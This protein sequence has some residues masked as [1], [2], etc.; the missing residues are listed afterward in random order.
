MKRTQFIIAISCAA[1]LTLATSCSTG[2]GKGTVWDDQKTAGNYNPSR[3]L[4]GHD[5]VE[6]EES[7]APS[8]EDFV[9][10]NNDDLKAQFSDGAAPQ[11]KHSPGEVGSRLPGIEGFHNP[12][13]AETSVFKTLYFNTDDHI[14]RDKES[15]E[16]LQRVAA[17][18]NAHP[19]VFIFV[20]GNCDE[21]GPEGYNLALGTRRANYVRTKLIE[22]GVNPERIHTVSYGKERP[23]D[24]GHNQQ[25]WA[26]NRRAE[27]KIYQKS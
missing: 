13:Q 2:T 9:A 27:F 16:A 19:N 11:P 10:L 14:V 5:T 4:W 21:R 25:A 6:N 1:L 20:S 23:A 7:F 17:Y 12:T 22:Q 18:L 3:S 15:L 8:Y 24:L 26:K